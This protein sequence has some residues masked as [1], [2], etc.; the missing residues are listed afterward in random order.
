[1]FLKNFLL[2]L[3]VFTIGFLTAFFFLNQS[4]QRSSPKILKNIASSL[5]IRKHEVIGFLPYWLIDKADKDYTKYITTLTYF[6]LTLNGNGTIQKLTSPIEEEPGWY[7]LRTGRFDQFR[8]QAKKNNVELSLL[9]FSAD[10]ETIAN[11]ISHPASHAANLVNEV[12]PIMKEHGF[13]DLNL[14]IE[15]FAPYASESA[16]E[17][18][19][20]FVKEVTIR[21]KEQNLGTVTIDVSP[22]D[23]V[24]TRLVDL[25]RI[26]PWIDNVVLMTYDYH[27]LGSY[28]TGAVAPIGGAGIDAEFDVETGIQKA[29]EILPKE[30]IFLGLPLY[31]YEWETVSQQPRSAV[32][33]ASG[34]VI[35]H[36]R[37][38]ELLK[39]CA[40][41]S[42][43]IEENSRESYVVYED[44]VT[45]T[46]HQIFFP[47]QRFLQEKIKLANLY[48]IA[49]VALWA[50]GYEGN[51]ILEPLNDYKNTLE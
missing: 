4:T 40:T 19:A 44:E 7:S 31:G 46:F 1:M 41:C 12:S 36:R 16:R 17:N 33:P 43:L 48:E 39:T 18:F 23:L 35:S 51:N 27:Y 37:A 24:K 11:L 42:A 34:L 50:I 49:G 32:L 10:E 20:A 22:T 3:F 6:G 26:K 5:G 45:G 28:V 14:D 13:L 25:T 15:S 47:D 9:V 30:K 29:V 21:I 2:A 38:E 8:D